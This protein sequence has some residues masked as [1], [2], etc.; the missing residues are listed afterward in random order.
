M[1]KPDKRKPNKTK[2]ADKPKPPAAGTPL[3]KDMPFVHVPDDGDFATPKAD[4]S[5]D[6]LKEQED[7]R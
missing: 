2:K 1:S 6:E 4:L 5:E 7:R 3:P